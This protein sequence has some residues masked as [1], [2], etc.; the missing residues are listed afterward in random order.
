MIPFGDNLSCH[1]RPWMTWALVGL[2]FAVFLV[3]WFL[4]PVTRR[5]VFHVLGLVPARFAHPDW[6]AAA[7]YPPADPL[8][9]FTALFLHA[10]WLHVLLNQ[11]MLWVFGDNIEDRM[12]PW[13]FL[14]FY[15]VCGA[16][17][18]AAHLYANPDSAVPAAGASGAI[19]GVLGAF[20]LLYPKAQLVLWI[21]VFLLPIFIRIPAIAF[22]GI[23]VMLQL[24]QI[25]G[26]P[27]PAAGPDEVAWWGH[28]GGFFAGVLLHRLFLGPNR[29]PSPLT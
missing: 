6:A 21:P 14:G 26:A 3:L 7:G 25:T 27:E 20:Y 18:L 24:A 4:D 12:G 13:R 22:L 1:N 29:A 8:P 16:L 28:V 10:G 5:D 23:W 17:S 11:W 19:A 9:F 2:N 15:L